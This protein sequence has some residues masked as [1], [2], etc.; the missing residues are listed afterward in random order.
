MMIAIAGPDGS[1]KSSVCKALSIC[2]DKSTIIYAG[3]RDFVLRSTSFGLSTW[4]KIKKFGT[5]PSLIAQYF[6]YF[7][8]EYIENLIRFRGN[9]KSGITRIYDRH[10]L[11]RVMMKYE[12][13]NRFNIGEVKKRRFYF[14]YPLRYLW[15]F[16]YIQFFPVIDRVY[17]L[18]P[19]PNLCFERSG[20]QYKNLSD[21]YI[22][23]DS[24]KEAVKFWGS[25]QKQFLPIQVN[26]DMS[27]ADIRD[28]IISDLKCL[29]D[30]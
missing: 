24:Y 23:V 12:L 8:L 9:T 25:H 16:L 30:I 5:I 29:S 4:I 28:L 2:I 7:P 6:L 17:V 14:E 26:S 27:V 3:K 19:D 1:G 10:P 22:R 15:A 21:A 11:D 13:R 20:G 18:L